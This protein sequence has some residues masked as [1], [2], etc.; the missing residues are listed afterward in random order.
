MSYIVEFE[1][2]F[3]SYV[4]T[5]LWSS[6]DEDGTPLDRNYGPEDL[7]P[8]TVESMKR[9][10][11]AFLERGCQWIHGVGLTTCREFDSACHSQKMVRP[12]RFIMN[13]GDKHASSLHRTTG[14]LPLLLAPLSGR[15]TCALCQG[16]RW[17]PATG[18]QVNRREHA[19]RG[20]SGFERHRLVRL[21]HAGRD[22]FRGHGCEPI[23]DFKQAGHDFW[24]TRN[25]H[26]AGFWDGD[27]PE[28][29]GTE[30]TKLSHSFGEVWLIGCENGQVEQL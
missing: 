7:T 15:F 2:F 25:H 6:L 13:Q 17:H 27:Y 19:F 1:T 16:G 29:E 5:A 20:A 9:D 21:A 11:R 10:C 4:E 26:G 8:E 18:S 12:A 14:V 30:L 3:N 28:P 22:L 23:A 24:L